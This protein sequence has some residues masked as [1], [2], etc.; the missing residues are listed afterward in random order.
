M[1]RPVIQ[2]PMSSVFDIVFL[3]YVD[4]FPKIFMCSNIAKPSVFLSCHKYL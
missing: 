4:I 2:L 1:K 3:R